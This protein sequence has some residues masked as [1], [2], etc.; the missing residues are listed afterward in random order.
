V[1][2]AIDL[3]E[4]ACVQLEGGRYDAERVRLDDP[5][6]VAARWRRAG[7]SALHVV[8]LDAATGR[9]SNAAPILRLLADPALEVQVGGGIRTEQAIQDMFDA[10]ARR[11]VLGTRAIEEPSWLASITTAFPGRLVVAADVAD[12]QVLTRGWAHASGRDVFDLVGTLDALPLAG[13]LVTAVHR[14]GR[15]AGTDL[16]LMRELAARARP[17]LYASGGITTLDELRALSDYGVHAA[18][19]G[20]ALY[21]GAL[22]ARTLAMEFAA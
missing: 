8:D 2:P 9:G 15:L 7:F 6:E 1:I 14:E 16:D 17:P 20:M 12:R 21:T 19:L 3:R 4:G 5:L 18:I 22:D 11:I 10:G 13:V